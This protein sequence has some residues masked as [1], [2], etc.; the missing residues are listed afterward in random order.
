MDKTMKIKMLA[1]TVIAGAVRYPGEVVEVDEPTA[2]YLVGRGRATEATKG[3]GAVPETATAEPAAETAVKPR[4][5][6]RAKR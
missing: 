6:K 4:A 3:G 1:P 2:R 5:R